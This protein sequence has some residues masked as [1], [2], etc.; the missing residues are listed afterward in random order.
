VLVFDPTNSRGLGLTPSERLKAGILA[1]ARTNTA[2]QNDFLVKWNTAD[3]ILQQIPKLGLDSMD[4]LIRTVWMSRKGHV[5]KRTMDQVIMKYIAGNPD[6][7]IREFTAWLQA[8]AASYSKLVDPAGISPN[9]DDLFDLRHRRGFVMCYP[10]LAS[11]LET[12]TARFTECVNLVLTVFVRNIMT[13]HEQASDYE[14]RWPAWAVQV[15]DGQTSNVLTAI[16]TRLLENSEFEDR[17]KRR[18]IGDGGHVR[19]LLRKIEFNN[20]A[21]GK[22]AQN[23]VDVEHIMP[24]SLESAIKKSSFKGN[25]KR[26]LDDMGYALPLSAENRSEILRSLHILGNQTLWHWIDNRA[27][28]DSRFGRKRASYGKMKLE[29]TTQL[30][31]RQIWNPREIRIRDSVLARIAVRVWPT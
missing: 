31:K 1:R 16:R 6:Q 21:A 22:A 10:F 7:R 20:P 24:K 28:R 26:W 30:A 19:Y 17:F 12:D 29:L 23:Q 5:T 11:V 4:E 8:G 15:R 25:K 14:K 9:Y 27:S 2:V 13:G 3:S 18:P